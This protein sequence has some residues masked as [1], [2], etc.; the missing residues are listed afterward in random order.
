MDFKKVGNKRA[1]NA[2]DADGLW[3]GIIEY[4]AEHQEWGFMPE[5]DTEFSLKT[6]KEIVAFIEEVSTND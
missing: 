1:Y 6:L 5:S 4:N 3:A 2:I